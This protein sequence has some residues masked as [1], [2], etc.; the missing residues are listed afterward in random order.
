[1]SVTFGKRCCIC[2]PKRN[3]RPARSLLP[4][5]WSAASGNCWLCETYWLVP[6]G[7]TNWKR[8]WRGSVK[9]C[10]RTAC[11]PW[12][13]TESSPVPFIPKYRRGGICPFGAWRVHAPHYQS[14]GTLGYGI[15][16]GKR[17]T[18]EILLWKQHGNIVIKARANWFDFQLALVC[19]W[20]H[21]SSKALQGR[22]K[23]ENLHAIRAG[24]KEFSK[25]V[26][27]FRLYDR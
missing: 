25:S 17:L 15:Q 14:N 23:K 27:R 7:S 4:S 3:F 12:R 2:W 21:T 8:T 16:K 20:K 13:L 18:A 5:R 19:L 9:R 1:M 26:R 6:S 11:A 22:V 10:W 24:Y